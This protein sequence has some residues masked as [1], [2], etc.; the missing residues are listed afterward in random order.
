MPD[1]LSDGDN[2][3]VEERIFRKEHR[4]TRCTGHAVSSVSGASDANTNQCKR[5]DV[6]R[7]QPP[8][9][10]RQQT[11]GNVFKISANSSKQP[12]RSPHATVGKHGREP[13]IRSTP[14]EAMWSAGNSHPS[15]P[16]ED[17]CPARIGLW[18]RYTF[19]FDIRSRTIPIKTNR[20]N[21]T[22]CER[23]PLTPIPT[24]PPFPDSQNISCEIPPTEDPFRMGRL[25]SALS[26]F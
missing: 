21:R 20:K 14:R 6:L 7:W 1:G 26:I 18:C 8:V 19:H 3:F 22:G 11:P 10:C 25:H 9:G 15:I 24:R 5:L 17:N 2:V 4:G 13:R 16:R 12:Q 23:N